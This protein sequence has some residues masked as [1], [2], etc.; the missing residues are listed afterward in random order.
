MSDKAMTI[1]GAIAGLAGVLGLA[2]VVKHRVSRHEIATKTASDK[3]T[4]SVAALTDAI[5][6]MRNEIKS[7]QD[8][9]QW[10]TDQVRALRAEN[11]SLKAHIDSV[12]RELSKLQGK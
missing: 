5:A 3:E 7:L 9:I 12:E 4:A 11:A 6:G 2:D 10:Y 1:G 8:D